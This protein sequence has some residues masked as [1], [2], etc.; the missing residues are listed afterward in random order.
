MI[1]QGEFTTEGLAQGMEREIPQLEAVVGTTYNVITREE[2]KANKINRTPF[3]EKVV[4]TV[5]NF[6]PF[7][8]NQDPDDPEGGRPR[9]AIAGAGGA[10]YNIYVDDIDVNVE[11][12]GD[13]SDEDIH[14]IVQEAQEEFGRK[15]LEALKDKR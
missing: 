15:L 8:P 1:E 13:G 9:V 14:E 12:S 5:R 3:M 6:K 2:A 10:T 4:E 7:N 11:G